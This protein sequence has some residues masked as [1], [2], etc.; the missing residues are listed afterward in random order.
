MFEHQ[1]KVLAAAGQTPHAPLDLDPVRPQLMQ[2]ERARIE[3]RIED[4]ERK[5][6]PGIALSHRPF[7]AHD[8]FGDALGR[9]AGDAVDDQ[10]RMR[11][12]RDRAREIAKP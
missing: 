10:A 12:A 4:A 7:D 2:E 9:R 1:G 5:D 8:L 11:A 3:P 6:I